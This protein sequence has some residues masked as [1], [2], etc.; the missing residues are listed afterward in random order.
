V[1]WASQP[2]VLSCRPEEDH[3]VQAVKYRV[4]PFYLAFATHSLSIVTAL[5]QSLDA[6]KHKKN[7]GK[8]IVFHCRDS[9]IAGFS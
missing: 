3:Y 2:E 4:R 1:E 9:V 6:D 7:N 5:V 8:P